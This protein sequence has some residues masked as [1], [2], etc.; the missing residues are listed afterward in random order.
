MALL[1]ASAGHLCGGG[2]LPGLGWLAARLTDLRDRRPAPGPPRLDSED[3]HWV[4]GPLS[5]SRP[6]LATAAHRTRAT[7]SRRLFR[8][9]GHGLHSHGR[10][11]ATP[12][13]SAQP[14]LDHAGPRPEKGASPTLPCW[15]LHLPRHHLA[16]PE[17]DAPRNDQRA[18]HRDLS[19]SG[20]HCGGRQ[21][22]R[23]APSSWPCHRPAP[24]LLTMLL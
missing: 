3:R 19:R 10:S 9:E 7:Q 23:G 8:R 1:P 18:R 6:R 20:R 14:D 24:A 15:L 13:L 2:L 22:H 16:V 12:H 11:R 17:S 21:G 5:A 4:V